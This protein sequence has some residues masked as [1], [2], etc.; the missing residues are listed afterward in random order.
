MKVLTALIHKYTW[1]STLGFFLIWFSLMI[2]VIPVSVAQ[3]HKL[4]P[5]SWFMTIE[6]LDVTS[7]FTHTVYFTREVS[8]NF[9]AAWSVEIESADGKEVC[10][11]GSVI[12]NPSSYT[13]M[14]KE[15]KIFTLEDFVGASCDL[16]DQG[17]YN[18]SVCWFVGFWVW[19]KPICKNAE[20]YHYHKPRGY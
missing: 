9:R 20:F 11:G 17:A 16:P 12:G 14:E 15:A 8:Q 19:T 7:G 5:E 2:G 13:K 1:E 18:L 4:V 3:G 10:H 6:K